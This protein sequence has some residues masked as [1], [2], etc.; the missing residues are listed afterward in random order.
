MKELN[1]NLRLTEKAAGHKTV[2][3]ATEHKSNLEKFKKKKRKKSFFEFL[4]SRE[5]KGRQIIDIQM[6]QEI[7]TNDGVPYTKRGQRPFFKDSL[8]ILWAFLHL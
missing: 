1:R 4:P 2:D 6:W 3:D 8:R 7:R 5:I